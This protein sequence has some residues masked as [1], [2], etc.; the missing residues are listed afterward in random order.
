M[1]IIFTLNF[2][3]DIPIPLLYNRLM[4]ISQLLALMCADLSDADLNAIR[5]ARGFSTLETASRDSFANFFISSIGVQEVMQLLTIE[6]SITLH[7]LQQTGEVSI[8]FFERLYGSPGKP[9]QPFYG[10]YTQRYKPTFEAVKKNLMRKGLLIVAEVKQRGESVQMERWRFALP[11]EFVPY[12]PPILQTKSIDQPGEISDRFIRKKLLQLIGGGPA[13][14]NDPIAI[15]IK[16]GI[17]Q[18]DDKPFTAKNIHEWQS[19][20]WKAG[21]KITDATYPTPVDAVRSLFGRLNPG[22]WVA[23]KSLVPVL[24]IFC[25]GGNMPAV[26]K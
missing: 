23:A 17:I 5:K 3:F 22:Q 25:D 2:I 19:N 10:T 7:L 12:L 20:A 18:L 8:P 4:S 11:P 24:K 26:E 14:T 6:E 16:S 9:G 15:D 21:L 1:S 13:A